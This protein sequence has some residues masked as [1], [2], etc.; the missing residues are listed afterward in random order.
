MPHDTLSTKLNEP[1]TKAQ[2]FRSSP[3]KTP[4]MLILVTCDE[5]INQN[6]KKCGK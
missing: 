4:S 5:G 1:Y 3:T 2:P 6:D